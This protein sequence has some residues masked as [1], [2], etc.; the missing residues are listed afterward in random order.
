MHY[1]RS[2]ISYALS[3][4]DMVMSRHMLC[5]ANIHA[6]VYTY[7]HDKALLSHRRV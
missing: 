7:L 6:R 5:V 3:T 2:Q 1:L 4:V